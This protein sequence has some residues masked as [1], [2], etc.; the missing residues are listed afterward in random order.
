MKFSQIDVICAERTDRICCRELAGEDVGRKFSRKRQKMTADCNGGARTGAYD[1]PLLSGHGRSAAL[2]IDIGVMTLGGLQIALSSGLVLRLVI[3][4]VGAFLGIDRRRS[5]GLG[6]AL[7]RG[8]IRIRNPV[9]LRLQVNGRVVAILGGRRLTV[10]LF[11][12]LWRGHVHLVA[13]QMEC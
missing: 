2:G 7:V 11:F 10:R 8:G 4:N 12:L 13:F 3:G 9:V 1:T 6:L 5:V